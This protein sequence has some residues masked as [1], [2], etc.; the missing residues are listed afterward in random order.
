VQTF[1]PYPDFI[2]SAQVLDDK[3]LNRQRSET[4]QILNVVAGLNPTSNWRHHPAVK[5]WI[6]FPRPLAL[7]GIAICCEH[8]RRGKKDSLKPWF[9]RMASQL[10]GSQLP[11]WF[12]SS[13]FH[14]S[15]RSSLLLKNLEHYAQFGWTEQPAK[16]Y[17]WP[18]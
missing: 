4:K 10:R 7:Y 1:L 17:V 9:R 3:R 13:E 5:M 8:R 12:G 6:G 11:S 18:I 2:R 14:A 15:H 16:G